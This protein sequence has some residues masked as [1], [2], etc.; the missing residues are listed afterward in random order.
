M[1]RYRQ[2]GVTLALIIVVLMF[3]FINLE[4][5]P[6]LWWDEGWTLSVARNWVESGHYGLLRNGAPRLA[7]L[8]GHFPIVVS[9]ALSFRLFGVG[10]WQGRL[11]GVLHTL[12]AF[13]LIFHLA[14]R[15]YGRPVAFGAIAMLLFLSAS[16]QLHP[17][18]AGRQ[19]LGETHA[20]A[21]LLAGYIF[22]LAALD[23]SGWFIVPAA[24]MWAIALQTKAQIRPFW[25]LSILLPMGVALYKRHGRAAALSGIGLSGSLVGSWGISWLHQAMVGGQF[26]AEPIEGLYFVTAFVPN[27]SVRLIALRIAIAY[28]A[29]V[30]LGVGWAAWEVFRTLKKS[31]LA[32]RHPGKMKPKIG[33]WVGCTPHPTPN[34]RDFLAFVSGVEIVKLAFLGLV[35]SWLAWYLFFAMFWVR[36]LFPVLFM[37]SIFAAAFIYRATERFDLLA[38]ARKFSGAIR[39]WRRGRP[40][41][42]DLIIGTGRLILVSWM[43]VAFFYTATV[44]YLVYI[45]F[46]QGSVV[47]VTDYLNANT[48]PDA[49][50][51]TYESELFFLLDRRYHY[52][53]DQLH[54]Q[55]IQHQ[56]LDPSTPVDYDPLV[57]DPDYLVT[58]AFSS[59]FGLYDKTLAANEFRLIA[60]FPGYQIY[61]RVR[62]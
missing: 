23:R 61:E 46:P 15:L 31:F 3:S 43:M 52:P 32:T 55:L 38:V 54:V 1:R 33:G 36:Y 25:L 19:V 9:V 14:R 11:P 29:P 13:L 6:P 8:S 37:G 45:V 22:L 58:G 62:E 34:F 12:A 49:L 51:E 47:D 20:M 5:V 2:I 27:L 48:D 21:Y 50:I 39:A 16:D 26:L 10:I 30:L 60:G 18:L 35:G 7:G 56:Y 41:V 44:F 57:S 17:I 24:L 40:R 28:G 53:P 59:Q 42:R 4:G